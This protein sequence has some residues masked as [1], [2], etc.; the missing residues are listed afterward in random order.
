MSCAI[1]I[2]DYVN[3]SS[4]SFFPI[5]YVIRNIDR[6]NIYISTDTKPQ[7]ISL[8]IHDSVGGWKI[9]GT[10]IKYKLEFFSNNP[11]YFRDIT[12]T[13]QIDMDILILSFLDDKDLYNFCRVNK[14]A[15]SLLNNEN[16]WRIKIENQY[17]GA[18]QYKSEN[19]TW[20]KYYRELKKINLYVDVEAD[21]SKRVILK[22]Y[23]SSTLAAED[24]HLDIL[25]WLSEKKGILPDKWGANRAAANEHIEVLEWLEKREILP[26]EEAAIY[27][28][29]S[30]HLKV[31]E[32][33]EKREI[34]PDKNGANDAVENGHINVL[35]WLKK[36]RIF[37]DGQRVNRAA[38][39]GHL[40]IL[41]WLWLEKGIL[42]DIMGT[43]LAAEQGHIDILEWLSQPSINIL[44]DE[45]GA[46]WAASNGHLHILIWLEK[47]KILPDVEGANLAASNGQIDVL[48][49][50][51]DVKKGS[52]IFL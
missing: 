39:D 16:L 32:W 20:N 51:Y 26:N 43:N 22:N 5:T 10:D 29:E 30:G 33:L 21:K 40:D 17:L 50:L 47:K 4:P 41:E 45:E 31:L 23:F 14:Y 35:E 34:L 8:I 15:S 49:W 24:G 48:E 25:E 18:G 27:A 52:N 44:P 6:S 37:P 42:P 11:V 13:G 1:Q 7:E 12:L 3:V 2:N 38:R 19:K 46:N 9:Y 36:R 28:A